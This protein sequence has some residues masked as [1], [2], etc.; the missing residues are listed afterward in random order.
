M[1]G[2]GITS[3]EALAASSF[4]A[5]ITR[6]L[7]DAETG[8]TVVPRV[9]SRGATVRDRPHRWEWITRPRDHLALEAA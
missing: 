1:P 9:R 8:A 2:I 4:D 3:V 5:S 7:V 6:M